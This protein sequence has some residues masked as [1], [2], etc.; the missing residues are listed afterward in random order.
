MV[1]FFCFFLVPLLKVD[2]DS[3]VEP[4]AECFRFLFDM[5]LMEQVFEESC[6][7]CRVEAEVAVRSIELATG[8][9][10]DCCCCDC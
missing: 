5:E 6:A 8:C 9:W 4:L 3:L 10:C 7:S 1:Q 2:E